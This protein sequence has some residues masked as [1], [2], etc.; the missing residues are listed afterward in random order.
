MKNPFKR[1]KQEP[2]AGFKAYLLSDSSRS[3]AAGYIKSDGSIDEAKAQHDMQYSPN[4]IYS[5]T[6]PMF[7]E[8][9]GALYTEF[10]GVDMQTISM[11]DAVALEMLDNLPEGVLIKRVF[12]RKGVNKWMVRYQANNKEY[13]SPTIPGALAT[14]FKNNKNLQKRYE[15]KLANK[16]YGTATHPLPQADAEGTATYQAANGSKD[17]QK[18]E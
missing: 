17:D 10:L 7:R 15:A 2:E 6:L 18:S 13:Y 4:Q 16:G 11:E 9:I 14:L 1:N 5:Y 12:S 8:L 3:W